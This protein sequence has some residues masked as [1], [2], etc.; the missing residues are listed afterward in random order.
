MIVGEGE[1]ALNFITPVIFQVTTDYP[2]YNYQNEEF[3]LPICF[4]ST[5]DSPSDC[6]ERINSSIFAATTSIFTADNSLPA[7][8]AIGKRLDIG[9]INVNTW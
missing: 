4:V 9:T 3:M 6:I 7:V 1:S 2:N 5:V 8:E